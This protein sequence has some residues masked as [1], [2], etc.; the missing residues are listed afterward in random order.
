MQYIVFSE[1]EIIMFFSVGYAAASFSIAQRQLAKIVREYL[2]VLQ[3][4]LFSK[5]LK[6]FQKMRMGIH[7]HDHPLS[8]K[9][10]LSLVLTLHFFKS[11]V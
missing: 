8:R 7:V 5:D 9:S 4:A 3:Y 6:V 1:R 11:H 10:K 2:F